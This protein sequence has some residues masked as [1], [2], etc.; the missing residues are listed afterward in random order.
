M[1]LPIPTPS[2]DVQTQ[3][4]A[5]WLINDSNNAL[6]SNEAYIK[7]IWK[8]LWDKGLT[9]A[10]MQARL[11]YLASIPATDPSGATNVLTAMFAK[12]TRL[13]TYILGED[14]NAFADAIND[15]AGAVNPATGQVYKQYFSTGWYFTIDGTKPSGMAVTQP[16]EWE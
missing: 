14:P 10:Q 12:A 13:I 4:D 6:L 2:A 7:S 3:N 5:L 11:D 15:P 1:T 9:A 8:F 16:W